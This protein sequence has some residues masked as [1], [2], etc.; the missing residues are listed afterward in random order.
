[1]ALNSKILNDPIH[2]FIRLPKGIIF[3]LIEHPYFQRL[4]R[5]SQLG[6]S[7]LVYPGA[8][9]TRFHHAIGA[10]FLMTKA[11]ESLRLKG[12]VISQDEAIGAEIAILLHDIGHGPF[13]HALE[14]SI[15]DNVSHE[16]I[17][18]LIMKE[19]NKEFDGQLEIAI[20][21]FDNS[22][23]K[24]FLHQLVSSQLDM[25]RM[26]YLKRDSFYSGVQEG[27]IGSERIIQMLN[28]VDD[29]LVVESKG[30]YSV[31]KFL[32]ARRLMYWQ[33]YFHKTVVCAEQMLIQ[34]LKRAKYL[35]QNDIS[36]FT[37]PCLKLFLENNFTYSDFS[38]SNIF[39]AFTRLDDFDVMTCIKE[40][41]NHSDLI[42]STLSDNITQRNLF[43]VIVKEN[44]F[45]K[46][47]INK[48]KESILKDYKLKR[49]DIGYLLIEGQ[50]S[51][52]AY[53]VK[54]SEIN[55]LF[56]DKSLKNISEASDQHTI[57]TLSQKVNKFFI[58]F[59]KEYNF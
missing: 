19:L 21:I 39:R 26:D 13:S 14:H 57:D 23:P 11:I 46:S 8:H 54:E 16:E 18:I 9:H 55:I 53:K 50:I 6:L 51:N 34:L 37:T 32:I 22:Y 20:Q 28:I 10:M 44:P 31:E 29:N 45:E 27:I 15:S 38:N 17:S 3:D 7:Y 52:D 42:L 56:K 36:L 40:W 49:E 43:K 5:I 1:M 12:H 35:C 33:V 30:I 58:C 4:R 25:D 48:L 24:K 2:G 59:P 41:C 47:K